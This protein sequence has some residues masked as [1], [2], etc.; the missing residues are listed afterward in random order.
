MSCF[1]L[2]FDFFFRCQEHVSV[3]MAN[4]W[5]ILESNMELDLSFPNHVAEFEKS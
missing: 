2:H 3:T 5:H 1:Y 4:A